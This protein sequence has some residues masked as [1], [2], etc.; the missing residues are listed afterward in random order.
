MGI[1]VTNGNGT[2][3]IWLSTALREVISII[4]YLEELKM[5][6]FQFNTTENKIICKAFEDNECALE[7]ARSSKFRPQTKHINI[8]YHHFHDAIESGKI[9]MFKIGTLDQQADILTKPLRVEAFI[10]LQRLIM[11]W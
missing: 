1:K 11:G 2:Q 6:G 8:K 7:M 3:Y 10:K 4:D 5:D 9:K